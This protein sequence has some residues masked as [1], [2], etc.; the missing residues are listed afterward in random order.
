LNPLDASD[1]QQDADNDGSS[2]IAEFEA[3]T[4]PNDANSR[5]VIEMPRVVK[6]SSGGGSI[7]LLWMLF[8]LTSVSIRRRINT[9]SSELARYTG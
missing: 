2:N 9:V 8:I 6:T 3:G 5:P 1:A 7:G 4:D